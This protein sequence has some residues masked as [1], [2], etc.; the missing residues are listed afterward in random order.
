MA[1]TREQIEAEIN[2]LD[3]LMAANDYIGIKI[4]MGRAT[5]EE[6]KEQIQKSNDMA[7]RKDELKAMLEEMDEAE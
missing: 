2:G 3:Q 6:Y 5:V 4:A 1:M 7:A